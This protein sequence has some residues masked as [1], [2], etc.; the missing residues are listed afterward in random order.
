MGIYT[1][2]KTFTATF[3]FAASALLV[4]ICGAEAQTKQSTPAV[5]TNSAAGD[6]RRSGAVRVRGVH[7]SYG[8]SNGQRASEVADAIEI[9]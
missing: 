4:A 3:L 1:L 2:M 5:E 8:A 6:L 7:T 9:I